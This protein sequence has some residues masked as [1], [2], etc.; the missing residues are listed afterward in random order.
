MAEPVKCTACG[1]TFNAAFKRCP[2]CNAPALPAAAPTRFDYSA[3]AEQVIAG[4]RPLL[5]L[6]FHPARAQ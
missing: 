1:R 2:F 4:N 5:A 6:E 3:V